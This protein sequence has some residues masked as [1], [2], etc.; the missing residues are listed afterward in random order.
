MFLKLKIFLGENLASDY[1]SRREQRIRSLL[2]V[3]GEV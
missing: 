2:L 1:I 3:N